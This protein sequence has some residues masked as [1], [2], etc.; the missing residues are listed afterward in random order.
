MKRR[1]WLLAATAAMVLAWAASG[2][3][4]GLRLTRRARAPYAERPP[5]GYRDVRLRTADGLSIGAWQRDHPRARAAVVLAHGNG[6]SLAALLDEAESFFQMGCSVLPISLRAH[7]DSDGE[8][9]D[10]GLSARRDVAAAVRHLRA[11]CRRCPVIVYGSSLGAAAALFAAPSL[12]PRTHGYV[13]VAPYAE[14]RE[15]VR[16]RTSRYLPFGADWLAYASLRLS[17]PLVLPRFDRINPVEAAGRAPRDVPAIVFA[18]DSDD[19]API[20]DARRI[21]RAWGHGATVV[22]VT[23][24]AHEELGELVTRAEWEHASRLVERVTR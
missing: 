18:S 23:G 8:H 6:S 17:A 15:A 19:R 22:S 4:V 2:W 12:G 11:T 16:R 20:T 24:L 14:L 5:A 13:L 3:V 21:A 9:N 1:R 7:G 10:M